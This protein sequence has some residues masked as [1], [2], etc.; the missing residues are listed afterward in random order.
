MVSPENSKK[1][2]ISTVT[3]VKA[4][5]PITT[6]VIEPKKAVKSMVSINEPEMGIEPATLSKDP[7]TSTTMPEESVDTLTIEGIYE[8]PETM[9]LE[10]SD[11]V[12][13]EPKNDLDVNPEILS[14]NAENMT[15]FLEI[16]YDDQTEEVD[17]Y[18]GDYD[19]FYVDP[20]D[21]DKNIFVDPKGRSK[22]FECKIC[23]CLKTN[24][25]D[26]K[27]HCF[28]MHNFC[29]DCDMNLISKE[30]T[31]NHMET[32][33]ELKVRCDQCDYNA[34]STKLVVQHMF[35]KHGIKPVRLPK[36]KDEN[37]KCKFCDVIKQRHCDL[38]KHYRCSHNFCNQ[39]SQQFEN[40]LEVAEHLEKKHNFDY[41]KCDLCLFVGLSN[42]EIRNHMTDKH[43][44]EDAE[45][46]DD[47]SDDDQGQPIKIIYM[48]EDEVIEESRKE[49]KNNENQIDVL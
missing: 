6:V 35:K 24:S 49:E 45:E 7:E 37:V 18:F 41:L 21:E 12:K 11:N 16:S 28:V 14:E 40:R 30:D 33:H 19:E 36:K 38:N 39:C 5:K 43:P 48:D 2:S 13:E 4:N 1:V 25:S 26:I 29:C 3:D 47:N 9:E 44:D 34:L 31:L 17:N 15:D 46:S 23:G 32:E 8:E 22:K 27:R 20:N 42:Y 10:Q